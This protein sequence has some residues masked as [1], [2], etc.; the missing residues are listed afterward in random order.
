LSRRALPLVVV[1]GILEAL[2]SALYV[3]GAHASPA[4]AAVLSSQFAA[5]AAVSAFVLFGERLA[6]IQL[7]G[8]SLVAIGVTALAIIRS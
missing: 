7:A 3:T 2:G 6:R 5:I 4:T 1:S 8:I